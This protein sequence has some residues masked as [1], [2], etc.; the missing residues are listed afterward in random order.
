VR[1][2]CPVEYDVIVI[3]PE[4]FS[5]FFMWAKANSTPP[6]ELD[7]LKRMA[8][9]FS[10]IDNGGYEELIPVSPSMR[11]GAAALVCFAA[12]ADFTCAERGVHKRSFDA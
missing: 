7:D 6:R 9:P 2:L 10:A 12:V 4:S 8:S 3:N 11:V 5:H 1:S